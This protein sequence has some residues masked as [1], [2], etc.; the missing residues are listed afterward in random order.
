G[1][2]VLLTGVLFTGASLQVDDPAD[3]IRKYT[4]SIEFDFIDWTLDALFVKNQTIAL[5]LDRYLSDDEGQTIL[6]DYFQHV[7][8]INTLRAE[9]SALY[10]DPNL[11]DPETAAAERAQRLAG[12][13]KENEILAAVS[14]TVLQRQVSVVAADLGLA[15]GGQLIPPLLYRMTPLPLAL[16]ISPREVIR[17]DADISLTA[18]LSIEEMV[19]LE[20]QIEQTEDVSALVVNIGGVGIYPT[21]VLRTTNLSWMIE[22]IAHEWVH[23]FLTLRPMGMLYMHTPQLRTMNETTASLAGREIAIEVYKRF[24]PQFVPVDT[25]P[26]EQT[27]PAEPIAPPE[28][29]RFDFN[30]E[31]HETRVTVDAMLAEGQIEQAEAYMEERRLYFRENGYQ[32]RRINQAY[33]AFYG[34]YADA[35]GGSAGED[36]VGPAVRKLRQQSDTLAQFLN[37]ISWMTS[38]ERLQAEVAG[39]P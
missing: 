7:N 16:I 2:L 15:A 12:M 37:R 30:D 28:P 38:F 32:L 14:E 6:S 31:M 10:A 21:M 35:P 1:L 4:R 20:Q 36:P 39:Q 26:A 5:G 19:A 3:A 18:D 33:F 22:T 23:N 9:I 29:P 25:S 34:A 8:D 11:T 24:Y 17:Q 27:T 13:E